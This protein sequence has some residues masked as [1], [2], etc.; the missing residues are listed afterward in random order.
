[1]M[2][3]NGLSFHANQSEEKMIKSS[4]LPRTYHNHYEEHSEKRLLCIGTTFHSK[5]VILFFDVNT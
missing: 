5:N 3:R 2:Y 1:M 4:P